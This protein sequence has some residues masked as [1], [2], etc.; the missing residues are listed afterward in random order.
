VATLLRARQARWR[1]VTARSL[2]VG[3]RG[4]SVTE[5]PVVASRQQGVADELEGTIGRAPGK[6]GAGR[7]HQGGGVTTGQRG[8]SVRRRAAGFSPEGGL[9][10][11]PAGSGS[12][13]GGRER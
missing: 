6:E 2:C 13:G 10:A 1:V 5:G 9:A 3:R 4:G 8:G 12:C 11:T 7:A